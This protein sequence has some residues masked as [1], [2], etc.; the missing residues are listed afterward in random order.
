[1]STVPLVTR[2]GTEVQ[3][4]EAVESQTGAQLRF[5]DVADDSVVRELEKSGFN[6]QR[7]TN[8]EAAGGLV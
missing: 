5:E 6:R 1:M 8:S 7:S 3:I 2:P 4:K